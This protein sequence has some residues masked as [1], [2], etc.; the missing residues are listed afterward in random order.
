M[1]GSCGLILPGQ[2]V[3][4][5]TTPASGYTTVFGYNAAG[6]NPGPVPAYKD[7]NGNAHLLMTNSGGGFYNVQDYGVLP[8]QSAA[9]NNTNI[10][11]LISNAVNN[12]VIFFPP[13]T[14]QF[15]SAIAVGSASFRFQGAGQ[16]FTVLQTTSATADIFTLTDAEWYTEFWDLWFSTSVTKTAGN[17]IT[18]GTASGSG[19]VGI[20]V[21]R[22][23]FSGTSGSLTLYNGI[24]YAG[25]NSGNITNVEDCSF[26]NFSNYG[27]YIEGNTSTPATLANIQISGIV[28][29]GTLTSG[30]AVAGIYVLQC[31]SCE[32]SNSDVI[33]CVNNLLLGGT[34]TTSSGVFSVDCVNCY[35]DESFGS[36]LLFQSTCN[37]DRCT[38]CNCWFTTGAGA[39]YSA[40]QSNNTSALGLSGIQ[41]IGC[42]V[43]NTYGTTA[44]SFGFNV[45]GARDIQLIGCSV[46]GWTNGFAITPYSVANYTSVKI[47]D[48]TIGPVGNIA[49]NTTGILLNAG[50]FAYGDILISGNDLAG[51]TTALTNSASGWSSLTVSAQ[52]GLATPS[53]PAVAAS[54]AINTT[55]TYITPSTPIPIGALQVGTTYRIIVTGTCTSTA[56]N[57]STFVLRLGTAGTIA[58]TSV[59]SVTCTAAAS[60]TT[61]PF[62]ATFY[63]TIRTIGSG[64]TAM[65][66][67]SIANTGITGI[68]SNGVGGGGSTAT[69]AVNTTV[70]NFVGVSY[71]SAATTTTC[72]FQMAIVEVVKA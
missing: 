11:T 58:D 38:F 33:G 71:S 1:A 60:G 4:A 44:T 59:C 10:A 54:A 26:S 35:F 30:N 8:G 67:G 14:Y 20:N 3:A 17:A 56:A 40:I 7:S 2:S 63:V 57:V 69:S 41:F 15:A 53:V 19:N 18:T 16:N 48:S 47:Q 31:G 51:N 49:A 72:T 39:G 37:I 68:S 43:Y 22:C 24:V 34:S 5:T 23:T 12:S 21:R 25:T 64:G 62:T 45:T 32:M 52:P 9:T 55:S 66:S 50:S 61:I 29:N 13:G 65:G 42:Q 28:M 70:K 6:A 46:A 27:L 36:C